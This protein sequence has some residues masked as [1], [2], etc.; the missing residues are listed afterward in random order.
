MT[1]GCALS[2]LVPNATDPARR[3]VAVMG[4]WLHAEV[5]APGGPS[6]SAALEAAIAEVERMDALLGTWDPSAPLSRANRAPVGTP[7]PVPAEAAA[8][9]AEARGWAARTGG[10]FEPALGALVDAWGLRGGGRIPDADELALALRRVGAGA[11]RV[12]PDAATLTRL[13]D[14]AWVDTG[15]FGKGAA[16]RS[17]ADTLRARGVSRAF[18]DLG[19]QVLV[20]AAPGEAP[21]RVAVAHPALRQDTATLLLLRDVSAATSGNSERGSSVGGTAVGHILD[22][23]GGAPA[24]WWGSVTV[25]SADPFV[26]DV[27]STALYVLGPEAG[28]AWARDLPDVG[29]L[30]LVETSDGL[31]AVHN[32]AME[33]WLDAPPPSAGTSHSRPERRLP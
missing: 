5:A 21:W 31:E 20:L 7:T 16:L 18:L 8:L 17:A 29:V 24:P 30:F 15:G 25:V 26:A 4:T 10:A 19:G 22:P 12:D 27:L 28:L 6:A 9:L 23:R 14:G 13:Q 3:T 2:G 32:Q 11:V 1:L 33:R